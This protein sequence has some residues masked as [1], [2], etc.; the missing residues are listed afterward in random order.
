MGLQ[1]RARQSLLWG[2]ALLALSEVGAQSSVTVRSSR[3]VGGAIA[4]VVRDDL[5]QPVPD[6]R[7]L[8]EG[9]ARQTRTAPN[10]AFVLEGLPAGPHQVRFRKLGFAEA[11]ADLTVIADSAITVG[12]TLASLAG[13]LDPVVIQATV[14]NQVTGLV[15][16]MSGTPLAGVVIEVLGLNIRLETNAEGRYVLLDLKP[17]NYLLQFRAPGFRVSQYGLRMVEQI[18]RDITTKL[19]P[20]TTR[21][22]MTVPVAAAVALEA[23]RRQS[24]RGGQS[25]LLGRDELERY[26]TQPLGDALGN[27]RANLLLPNVNTS[28][29]LLN[30]YEP[31]STETAA[32]ILSGQAGTR[33]GG[34][35]AAQAQRF[36]TSASSDALAPRNARVASGWLNFFR[37]N[38]VEML[39]I[40][41][42]GSENSRTVCGRFPPSS[43]CSCPPDPSA[44]VIWLRR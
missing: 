23:T 20:A 10:G 29:I 11:Q 16:D 15:T 1:I 36:G 22:R 38:E 7:V 41:A 19:Q 9:L 31:L 32:E 28:C 24:L 12:V 8:V 39:E 21:D 4:G 30:G 5:G 13:Q 2:L 25:M 34:F 43:G 26:D 40:Y 3:P 37:A 35:T 18:E 27:T 14:L 42:P 17:G 6:V 44:I 33:S